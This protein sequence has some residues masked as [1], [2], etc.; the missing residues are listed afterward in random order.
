VAVAEIDPEQIAA[1]P[2]LVRLE[3]RIAFE[4]W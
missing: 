1:R 4:G 3:E 2:E